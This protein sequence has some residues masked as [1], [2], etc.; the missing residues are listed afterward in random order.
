MK[1]IVLR[2]K[3]D[4]YP[5]EAV[6]KAAYHFVE[7][8]YMH[9]DKDDTDYI[10]AVTAKKDNA[11]YDIPHELENEVLSQAVRYYVYKQTHVIRELLMARAMSSTM[12]EVK[13]PELS[14][15]L[16]HV[17]DVDSILTDWFEKNELH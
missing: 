4:L 12:V 1:E 14:D 7:T 2:F 8:C 13:A 5:K 3:L 6:M 11:L 10:I 17:E 9:V 15:E 16:E